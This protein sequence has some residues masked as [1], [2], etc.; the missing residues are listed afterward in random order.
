MSG[1]G[2]SGVTA[3]SMKS[4]V[5]GDRVSTGIDDHCT[6]RERGGTI[7]GEPLEEATEI[8]LD[9]RRSRDAVVFLVELV[10]ADARG[11]RRARRVLSIERTRRKRS[12]V[13]ICVHRSADSRLEDATGIDRV[14]TRAHQQLHE[15]AGDRD[16]DFGAVELCELAV[17]QKAAEAELGLAKQ[18]FHR[19]RKLAL[20]AVV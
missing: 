20:G 9:V 11:C 12:I 1:D 19:Q 3:A 14:R 18:L 2:A 4:A 6:A 16:R 15:S 10:H 5:G 8:N 7:R 17:W 13:A